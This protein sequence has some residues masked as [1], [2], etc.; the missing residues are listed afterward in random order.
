MARGTPRL[1]AAVFYPEM[2][3][4]CPLW[5]PR[6]CQG[7][8]KARMKSEEKRRTRFHSGHGTSP[9]LPVP[10]SGITTNLGAGPDV[11]D[12]L[13]ERWLCLLDWREGKGNVPN[14][15]HRLRIGKSMF[16]FRTRR[17]HPFKT[18]SVSHDHGSG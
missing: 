12:Q 15:L 4:K 5:F 13:L 3:M 7:Y 18:R 6:R 16:C 10:N 14:T 8:I 1:C 17:L 9:D 11:P 2:K